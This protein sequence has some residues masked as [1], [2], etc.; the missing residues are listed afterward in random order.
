MGVVEM[1]FG[2]VVQFVVAHKWWIA[3]LIPFVIVIVVLRLRG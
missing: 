2:E 3:A 1:D